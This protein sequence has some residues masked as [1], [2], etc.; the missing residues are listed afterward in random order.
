[1]VDLRLDVTIVSESDMR[2]TRHFMPDEETPGEVFSMCRIVTHYNFEGGDGP[3][4]KKVHLM[5]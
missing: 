5:Q 2:G 1:V 3:N 4:A